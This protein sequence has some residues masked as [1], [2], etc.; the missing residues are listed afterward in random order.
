MR[1]TKR[2]L[3]TA[4]AILAAALLVYAKGTKI[5]GKIVAYDVMLHSSKSASATQNQEVV[6]IETTNA[7]HKYVK[8]MFSSFGTTQIDPKYFDGTLPMDVDVFRDHSCDESVPRFVPQVKLEQI[9]KT[10]L[11]TDAFKA[12]PPGRIKNLT[13]YVAIYKKKK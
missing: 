4:I 7:K 6:V 13:C 2:I 12:S 10:Y 8:V 9:A 5:T 11:L 3:L 1:R